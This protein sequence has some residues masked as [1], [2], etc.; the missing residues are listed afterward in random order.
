MSEK[1]QHIISTDCRVKAFDC[2]RRGRRIPFG[3]FIQ[4]LLYG[5]FVEPFL[6]CVRFF[7]GSIG[8]QL[9]IWLGQL[10]LRHLGKCSFIEFGAI[11][12]SPRNISI[13]DYVLIDRHV[14][15]DARGGE[16]VIGRRVH[17]GVGAHVAGM[18]GVFVGDY[19]AI[20]RNA[21]VLSHSE[22]VD[23]GKR[24][25]GPMIP[26]EFKGMKTAPVRLEKDSVVG[27]GAIILPGVTLGEGAIAASNSLVIANV[28][29]G[30]IVMG[31]PA[32]PVGVRG[33]VT[34][35]DM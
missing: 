35:P 13:A 9:R 34:V 16:I 6:F 24:M 3:T 21:Q 15:L 22:V 19:A 5:L 8:V 29:P 2:M 28:K 30:Q 17:I 27:A 26:E 11:L 23:G 10:T 18:G 31:V 32:R 33:P 14:E 12:D 25:S 4:V 20:G 1:I 7:P